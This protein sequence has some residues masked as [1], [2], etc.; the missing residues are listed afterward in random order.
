M[1][2]AHACCCWHR[3]WRRAGHQ[4]C[5][6]RCG[7]TERNSCGAV[8]VWCVQGGGQSAGPWAHMHVDL[9][10]TA[11]ASIGCVDAPCCTV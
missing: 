3:A 1:A 6:I 10:G 5:W 7:K 11:I 9:C 4:T 8:G 2:E